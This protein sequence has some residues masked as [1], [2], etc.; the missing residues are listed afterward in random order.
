V[1]TSV[2]DR[3]Q[4]EQ[5]AKIESTAFELR[6]IPQAQVDGVVGDGRAPHPQPLVV[7][8]KSVS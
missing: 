2:Y 8:H 5:G 1:H 3:L 4:A 7:P 6:V